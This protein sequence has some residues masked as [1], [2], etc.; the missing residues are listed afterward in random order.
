MVA[1]NVAN[2]GSYNWTLPYPLD[3]SVTLRIMARDTVGNL[4]A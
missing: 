2:S 4:G 1:N 3:A